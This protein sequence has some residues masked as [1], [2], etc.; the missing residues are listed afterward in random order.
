VKAVPAE[1]G[2]EGK[3]I[4]SGLKLPVRRRGIASA[5]PNRAKKPHSIRLARNCQTGPATRPQTLLAEENSVGELTAN[6]ENVERLMSASGWKA[7]VHSI[8]ERNIPEVLSILSRRAGV[9]KIS[10]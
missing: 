8:I 10:V 2:E 4:H 7:I 5:A 1:E 3:N 9:M 6:N